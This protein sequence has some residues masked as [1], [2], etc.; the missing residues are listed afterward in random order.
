MNIKEI[1]SGIAYDGEI[2]EADIKRISCDPM[3]SGRGILTVIYKRVGKQKKTYVMQ[4]EAITVCE[5]DEDISGGTI[6]RVKN[7][8]AA[9]SMLYSNLSG[10]D[11]GR[12]TFIGITGTNGK[13]TTATLCEHIL[14]YA[15]LNVGFIGT[16]RVE[17]MG[18]SLVDKEYSMTTPDP[19][20]LY[21][22]IK[23]MQ[24]MGCTHVV[25]EVS[26]QAIALSKL[27]PI[28]FAVGAFLNLSREHLD[29]HGEMENYYSTKLSLFKGVNI[30]IF[31][32]DDAYSTRAEAECGLNI[33]RTVAV[34]NDADIGLCELRDKKD[35]GYE[36]ICR[37][38]NLYFKVRQHLPGAFNVYNTLFAIGI[39][40]AIGI[41]NAV[42]RRAIGDFLYV[43]GRCEIIKDEIRVIIDYA[44][45]PGAMRD[46]LS[47]AKGSAKGRRVITLFGCGGERARDK[48]P[49][50]ARE[51]EKYSDLLVITEDNS[52]LEDPD[53]ILA[54]IISGLHDNKDIKIIP[55]RERAIRE[56]ILTAD[57]GDTVLIV[58]KGNEAYNDKGG[59]KRAFDERAIVRDAL[60]LRK[61]DSRA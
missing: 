54:D 26:S 47:F 8:R 17:Y 30:G 32:K 25:M 57:D 61:N 58:G 24:D 16:G 21:P 60:L 20:V 48:R 53:I 11:Y 49:L 1:F 36:Y 45:T 42:I 23:K 38:G 59:I 44:H 18:V 9:L 2:P 14:R 35:E 7:A 10:I 52:R 51:A 31:N 37:S 3:I 39:T 46:L 50:M 28:S 34:I 22:A 27:A 29:L 56:A 19:S 55:D 12:L 15:G 33:T 41:K 5:A 4:R 13:T 43:P 6:V 40:E